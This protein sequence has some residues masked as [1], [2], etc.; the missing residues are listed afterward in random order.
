MIE[1]WRSV[2]SI[3]SVIAVVQLIWSVFFLGAVGWFLGSEV[4]SSES[5]GTLLAVGLPVGTVAVLWWARARRPKTTTADRL[6]AHPETR[7]IGARKMS[8]GRFPSENWAIVAGGPAMVGV[9]H[10]L[11]RRI[12]ALQ[13]IGL[14]RLL[15]DRQR[16]ARA[17]GL[18]ENWIAVVLVMPGK[19]A[20]ISL[21]VDGKPVYVS[22]L[23]GTVDLFKNGIHA[24]DMVKAKF[25]SAIH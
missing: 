19:F 8:E 5:L 24:P 4:L 2:R 9:A 15:R 14:G 17:A 12:S 11:T 20:G 7:F 16:L 18:D 1:F 22:D 13:R 6:F 10:P 3:W 23:E 25:L 21:A